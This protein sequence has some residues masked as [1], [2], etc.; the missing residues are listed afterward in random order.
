[1]LGGFIGKKVK[2]P[3]AARNVRNSPSHINAAAIK[4]RNEANR[5]FLFRPVADS[6]TGLQIQL[7]GLIFFNKFGRFL[8]YQQDIDERII[9]LKILIE[10]KQKENSWISWLG[11]S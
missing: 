4:S 7:N 3:L 9:M 6:L 11:I 8:A 1:M 2:R 5:K 10:G